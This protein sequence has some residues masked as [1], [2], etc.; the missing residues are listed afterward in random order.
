MLRRGVVGRCPVC[1]SFWAWFRGWFR[2]DER[3]RTCRFRWRRGQDGFE[4]GS[5]IVNFVVTFG[6]I[7]GAMLGAAVVTYPEYPVRIMLVV[8]VSTALV[9]PVALFPLTNFVWSAVELAMH[10]LEADELAELTVPPQRI[11]RN[12]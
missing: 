3:C 11:R 12:A 6:V 10:P 9:L 4:T 8:L 5:M 1:G 2:R 7:I